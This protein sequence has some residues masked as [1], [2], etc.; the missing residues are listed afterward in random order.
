MRPALELFFA[1]TEVGRPFVAPPDI[2]EERL[3]ILRNAFEETMKDP[4]LLEEARRLQ[5]N[6]FPIA[7]EEIARVVAEAY[8]AP[9]DVVRRTQ[10][11]L[12]RVSE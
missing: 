1:R 8:E 9:S 7:G 11:A 12:G 3:T 10:A 4:E 5:L 6:P 2:P